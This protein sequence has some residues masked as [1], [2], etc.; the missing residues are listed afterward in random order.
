MSKKNTITT[1]LCENSGIISNQ[2]TVDKLKKE[3]KATLI[4]SVI[5]LSAV[6]GKYKDIVNKVAKQLE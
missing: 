4:S 1:G 6:I 2:K 3:L 5:S